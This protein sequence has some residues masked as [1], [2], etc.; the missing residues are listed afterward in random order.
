M[1]LVEQLEHGGEVLSPA[2][3]AAMGLR[4]RE[5]ELLRQQAE[6]QAT[7]IRSL[8]ARV[9][10]LEAQLRGNSTNSSRPPSSD[11]PGTVRPQKK[12]SSRKRG[13]QKA[14]PGHQRTLLP[15]ERVDA[16]V[17]HRPVACPH[18]G[19]CLA[20]APAVGTPTRHQTIELPRVRALVTEH[21][22]FTLACPQCRA[23]TR[24]RLPAEIRAPH[25]GPRRVAFATV[26]Q[27]NLLTDLS[28]L[29]AKAPEGAT[30]VIFHSAVLAY[31]TAEECQR[32]ATLVRELDAVWISNE[33]PDVLPELAAKLNEHPRLDQFL[34]CID[35]EPVAVTAPHGQSLRWLAEPST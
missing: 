17:E 24:A 1:R 5:N 9:R 29:A 35:G 16:V 21:R 8:V 13:G 15:P 3:R 10:E 14:H 33:S 23:H 27:G 20:G 12:K 31:L 7:R 30:L 2:V 25:F 34:L 19:P 32:F 18:R 11:P 6:L 22:A 4:E 28:A 26:L